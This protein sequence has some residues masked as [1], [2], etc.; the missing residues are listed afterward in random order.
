MQGYIYKTNITY[1]VLELCIQP[2][3]LIFICYNLYMLI[4]KNCTLEL[5]LFD[6]LPE[7]YNLLVQHYNNIFK[8][9]VKGFSFIGCGPTIK[10]ATIDF[11]IK[12]L[13][14]NKFTELGFW[15]NNINWILETELRE[16]KK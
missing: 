6:I 7:G 1:K 15:K 8:V 3:I 14:Q 5:L 11:Y 2:C 12:I 13:K 4:P 16:I 9:S 10:E